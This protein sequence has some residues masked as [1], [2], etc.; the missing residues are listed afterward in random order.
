MALKELPSPIL[1]VTHIGRCPLSLCVLRDDIPQLFF[2]PS[3]HQIILLVALLPCILVQIG[4]FDFSSHIQIMRE[5]TLVPCMISVQ[6]FFRESR[7][8]T[9]VTMT[10]FEVCTQDLT[11]QSQHSCWGKLRT[12]LGSRYQL[13]SQLISIAITLT[14]S[15][16]YFLYLYR[17]SKQLSVKFL[18][19]LFG[20][21]LRYPLFLFL[22]FCQLPISIPLNKRSK[23]CDHTIRDS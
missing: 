8:R 13:P 23:S 19:I 14:R 10:R 4:L 11:R 16:R 5:F 6:L 21:F 7:E 18:P 3:L 1:D 2:V 12:V 20:F 22:L 15:K 17:T 9:L